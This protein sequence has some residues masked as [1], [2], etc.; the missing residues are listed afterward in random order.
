MKKKIKSKIKAKKI[1]IIQQIRTKFKIINYQTKIKIQYCHKLKN[2]KISL[3]IKL[4]KIMI[5]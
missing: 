3:T 1:K 5:H 4:I 2:K